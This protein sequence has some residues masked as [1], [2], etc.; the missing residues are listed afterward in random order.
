MNK[1]SILILLL[2]LLTSV[3][4]V[5][6]VEDGL[7]IG[8]DP[9]LILGALMAGAIFLF[10]V[11]RHPAVVVAPMLF[12]SPEKPFPILSRF[13]VAQEFTLLEATMIVLIVAMLP[14]LWALSRRP[15]ALQNLFKGQGKAV[16]AWL[17]F[18]AIVAASYAYTAAPDWGS[19]K[20][21]RFLV[22]GGL[23]F[24]AP[25]LL[26]RDKDDI[27]DFVI[28]FLLFSFAV[29]FVMIRAS[30]QGGRTA[31]INPVH[32]GIAQFLG[33]AIIIALYYRIP[34]NRRVR[35]LVLFVV[36]P[37]LAFGLVSALSRGPFLGLLAVLTLSLFVP[38]LRT[39]LISR[40]QMA[41]SL[42]MVVVAVS[43]LASGWFGGRVEA[44]L[45]AK[46]A[47][48]QS[49]S[50]RSGRAHGSAT[51]RLTL[52]K[53][54]LQGIQERP[55]LGWGVGGFMRYNS[56]TD[57]P[58]IKTDIVRHFN[59]GHDPIE[60]YPHN[61]FLEVGFEEGMLGLAALLILLA[62][63]FGAMRKNLVRLAE[64]FPFLLPVMIYMLLITQVS[65]D[66]LDSRFLWFWCG[67]TLVGC[68]L[69]QSQSL[70]NAV[71]PE[72]HW[73][74]S[75]GESSPALEGL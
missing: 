65:G 34:S 38:Q 16:G 35:A 11:M 12:A 39:A 4:A 1:N 44:R 68:Q 23:A 69:A 56:Y 66:I 53:T 67:V 3:I 51:Q 33:W 46:I 49:L 72:A 17:A 73:E 37:W 75:F 13:H 21:A 50:A 42:V 40:R 31:G 54:A 9:F 36:I 59:T 27:R 15:G 70:E 71:V 61:L 10:V 28:G 57:Y 74:E 30:H 41:L 45:H 55:L 25:F 19:Y 2:F 8:E 52:Y 26:F 29:S 18:M 62:R 48:L 63:I 47:E 60:R 14:R 24:F 58:P 32:I 20:L 6:W 22:V 5:V 64:H 43:L 7:G